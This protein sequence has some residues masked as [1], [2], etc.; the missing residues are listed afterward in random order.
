MLGIFLTAVIYEVVTLSSDDCAYCKNYIENELKSQYETGYKE[1]DTYIESQFLKG[2]HVHISDVMSR[3]GLFEKYGATTATYMTSELSCSIADYQ[4]ILKYS[5][6]YGLDPDDFSLNLDLKFK[7]IYITPFKTVHMNVGF[8]ESVKYG[9]ETI[10]YGRKADYEIILKNI[11]DE[12][13][14]TY[15]D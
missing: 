3:K 7:N 6:K 9:D 1:Y 13:E 5:D 10:W 2:E 15:M 12:W 11:N 4:S 8:D 14:I